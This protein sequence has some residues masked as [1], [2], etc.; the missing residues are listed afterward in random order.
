MRTSL[1]IDDPVLRTR[2]GSRPRKASPWA[3]LV[4]DLLA[5]EL[6]ED[7]CSHP[8]CA[9][10]LDR[11]ADGR[12]R[13]S[14]RQ[15]SRA[16]RLRPMISHELVLGRQYRALFVGRLQSVPC[17]SQEPSGILYE[18]ERSTLS[19]LADDNELPA[20]F[21]RIHPSSMSRMTPVEAMANVETLTQ[22][23]QF[24]LSGRGRRILGDV[25]IR[26]Q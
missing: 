22:S 26:D 5:R 19:A 13:Q 20:H 14:L 15:G 6:K 11:K 24:T 10:G 18:S 3:E 21:R 8:Y 4:S 16:S 12:T 9:S 2:S 7:R 17:E 23:A 25:A 1:D